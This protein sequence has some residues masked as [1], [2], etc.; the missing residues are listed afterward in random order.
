MYTIEQGIEIPK[1]EVGRPKQAFPYQQM[2]VGDS[3]LIK[4]NG[5]GKKTLHLKRVEAFAQARKHG[6]AI[7]TR[8]V[9]GGIRVWKIR[10]PYERQQVTQ[11]EEA[12]HVSTM[13]RA[14][15]Q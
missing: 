2:R 3:F 11:Q 9:P 15:G 7:T 1:K 13:S 5:G 4:Q 10:K 6:I 12:K 8:S 14:N